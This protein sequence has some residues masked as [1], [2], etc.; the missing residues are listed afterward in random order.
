MSIFKH[1]QAHHFKNMFQHVHMQCL[2][3]AAIH[4]LI[5]VSQHLADC[6]C[7]RHA[8]RWQYNPSVLCMEGLTRHRLECRPSMHCMWCKYGLQ[9]PQVLKFV[10]VPAAQPPTP[11]P[12]SPPPLLQGSYI[13]AWQNVWTPVGMYISASTVICAPS[14]LTACRSWLVCFV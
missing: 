9:E 14:N 7:H 6:P 10:I 8:S 11:S 2:S 5:V 12:P 1:F 3:Y 13:V 4:A